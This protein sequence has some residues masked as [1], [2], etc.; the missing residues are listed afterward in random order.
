VSGRPIV[1]ASWA[2]VG[3]WAVLAALDAA[4]L[5]AFDGPTVAVSLA[6]FLAS[7]PAWAYA[8]ACAV[9]RSARGDD[10]AVA[11]LFFLQGSAPRDVRRRLVGAVVASTAVAVATMFANPYVVL[12]PML[13]LGLAGVWAAR[14]G[15]FPPRAAR[16]P[17]GGRR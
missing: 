6:L 10:I 16:A 7:L 1:V 8:F 3:A 11:S 9:A 14:H 12:V 13:P 15:T 4:G 2:T 5:D 17:R